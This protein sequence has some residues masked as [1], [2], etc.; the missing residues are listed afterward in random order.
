MD[1]NV[2]IA[3]LSLAGTCIG[4]LAGILTANKLVNYRLQQLE[5]KVTAHNNLVDRT[6][7]LESRMTSAEHDVNE[8]KQYHPIKATN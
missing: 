2:V 6:Y 3:V 7:K 4:S 5:D 1:S 8:L